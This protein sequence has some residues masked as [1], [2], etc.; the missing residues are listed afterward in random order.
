MAYP[1]TINERGTGY[2]VALLLQL[3][4]WPTHAAKA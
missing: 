2:G 4:V 3:F 1:A